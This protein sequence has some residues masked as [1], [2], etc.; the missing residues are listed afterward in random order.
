MNEVVFRF[1]T[2][3]ELDD[4]MNRMATSTLK[5]KKCLECNCLHIRDSEYCSEKCYNRWYH[6]EKYTPNEL[7][8]PLPK[9]ICKECAKE[10]Y[11][12]NIRA[13]YCSR[14]CCQAMYRRNKRFNKKHT[15]NCE[16]KDTQSVNLENKSKT[17]EGAM[18]HLAA[19]PKIQP[20]KRPGYEISFQ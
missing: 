17:Y 8:K 13:E 6:R 4:F 19:L 16:I 3:E 20:V 18:R 11:A 10:F 2:K 12:K 1:D 15:L 14:R 7:S 9:K 5:Q